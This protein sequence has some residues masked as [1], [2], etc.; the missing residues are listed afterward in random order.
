[1]LAR[2]YANEERGRKRLRVPVLHSPVTSHPKCCHLMEVQINVTASVPVSAAILTDYRWLH[3]QLLLYHT[4]SINTM[5]DMPQMR[6]SGSVSKPT[7]LTVCCLHRQ[8]RTSSNWFGTT[9]SDFTAAFDT[10]DHAVPIEK[11]KQDIGIHG[12]AL[13]WCPTRFYTGT[14]FI[15]FI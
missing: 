2:L 7:E 5:S 1:M 6:L 14:M 13:W 8:H 9:K 12:V 3:L 4:I 15:Y 11:I 10:I